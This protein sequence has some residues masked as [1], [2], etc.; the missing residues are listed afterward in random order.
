ML[1]LLG[2]LSLLHLLCRTA[3][4]V[5]PPCAPGSFY[6][7]RNGLGHCQPCRPGCACPDGTAACYGC[8]DGYYSAAAGAAAC[9]A[10]PAGTTSDALLNSGC[11]PFNYGTPCANAYGPLGQITCRPAPPPANV[12]FEAPSGALYAPPQ[13]QPGGPPYVP[14]IIPPYYSIYGTPMLQQSY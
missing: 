2:L 6:W 13:Y 3:D 12:T 10:C 5:Y 9:T 4:A 1:S 11:D 7:E 14:N 8:N